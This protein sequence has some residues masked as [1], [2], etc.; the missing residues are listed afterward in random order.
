MTQ[1]ER[2]YS[3]SETPGLV[4]GAF[5]SGD[6]NC[7]RSGAFVAATIVLSQ[8][9]TSGGANSLDPNRTVRFNPE[10]SVADTAALA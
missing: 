1:S 10:K 7:G 9:W 8:T 3:D 2:E 4:N 6:G 5:A